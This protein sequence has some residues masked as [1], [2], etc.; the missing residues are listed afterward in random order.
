MTDTL[1]YRLPET[2]YPKRYAIRL[3]PDLTHFTFAGEES[4]AITIKESTQEIVLNA[5][6]LTIHKV[7]IVDAEGNSS[8]G[9]ASFDESAER[10]VLHFPHVLPPGEW[11]LHISFEGILN[12]KLRGFYRSSYKDAQGQDTILAS[13][14][15]ESTD[16]RRA[17]PCWDEPA[18]KAVFQVTL[19]IDAGLTAISNAAIVRE[20]P[21][22]GTGKKEV[23]FADSMKMSTYLVAFIVGE[24]EASEPTYVDGK[25]LR[26]CSIPGKQHLTKFGQAIGTASLQFFSQYYGRPYPGDKLDLIAIPDFAAG[27]MEN[28]GAITFRETALLI[29]EDA[30]IDDQAAVTADQSG[31]HRAVGVG[32]P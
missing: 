20:T 6:E 19:V 29:D 32:D 4:V 13:T 15:F 25:P 11:Q 12:D 26:V 31:K 17:F 14:Q 28:L 27:A 23:V 30:A 21:Q 9:S 2:T 3:A 1:S 18:L 16:A 10:A 7:W 22:P 8:E 24:F 5:C